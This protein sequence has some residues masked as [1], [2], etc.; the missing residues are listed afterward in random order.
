M[1]LALAGMVAACCA[2]ARQ[3]GLAARLA[4]PGDGLTA[5]V[6]QPSLRGHTGRAFHKPTKPVP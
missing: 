2:A 6:F 4:A 5:M 1:A 3:G